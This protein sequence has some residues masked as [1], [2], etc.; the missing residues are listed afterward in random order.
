MTNWLWNLTAKSNQ[1]EMEALESRNKKERDKIQEFLEESSQSEIIDKI[2]QLEHAL[3]WREFR[4]KN[5]KNKK[6]VVDFD[7]NPR[8][9]SML[10]RE[11]WK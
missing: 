1:R 5:D 11:E 2:Q 8:E 7:M 4:Y 3:L 10:T 6:D 9:F